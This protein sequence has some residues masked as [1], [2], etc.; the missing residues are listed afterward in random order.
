[1]EQVNMHLNNIALKH[2]AH[3][4]SKTFVLIAKEAEYKQVIAVV[5]VINSYLS[6]T[7]DGGRTEHTMHAYLSY[8][9]MNYKRVQRILHMTY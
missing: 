6:E 4:P 3:D 5:L 9:P 1:M 2:A 8:F 7:I